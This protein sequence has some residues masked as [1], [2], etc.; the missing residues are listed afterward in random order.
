VTL[1]RDP[2]GASRDLPPASPF[3]DRGFLLGDGLFETIRLYGDHAFR[4]HAHL[5]RLRAG[6]QKIGIPIP[7]RLEADVA[8]VLK[9]WKERRPPEAEDGALRLTLTRG[10]GAGVLPEREEKPT[11]VLGASRYAPD[12]NLPVRGLRALVRGRVDERALTAGLKAIGYLER[13]VALRDARREDADEALLVNSIGRVVEGSASNLFAVRD[14][15]L[16]TPSVADGALP[17]ITREVVLSLAASGGIPVEERALP[18]EELT[19]ADE[20]FLTSSLRELAPVVSVEGLTIGSGTPGPAYR[21]M[22]ED[23][24]RIVREEA[25][26]DA[27]PAG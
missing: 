12:R 5:A 21:A 19:T 2:G 6:A 3:A 1:P 22:R 17:G 15:V 26:S 24:L 27:S 23:F 16:L 10:T 7:D 18:P 8:A 13:I 4:L 9:G 11:L 25:R 14:D 20:I